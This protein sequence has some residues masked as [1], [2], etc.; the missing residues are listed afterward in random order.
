MSDRA[1][2]AH[3]WDGASAEAPQ[4][5]KKANTLPG[6]IRRL[7]R[8]PSLRRAPAIPMTKKPRR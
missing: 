2:L 4:G 6:K 7:D 1:K 8:L 5:I 3:H